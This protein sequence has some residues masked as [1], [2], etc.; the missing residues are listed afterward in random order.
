MENDLESSPF[1]LHRPSYPSL[2]H[3]AVSSLVDVGGCDINL[4]HGCPDHGHSTGTASTRIDPGLFPDQEAI[5][6]D[7]N[8]GS[9][10]NLVRVLYCGTEVSKDRGRVGFRS[11]L[12]LVVPLQMSTVR[13]VPST[14]LSIVCVMRTVPT[15]C[16]TH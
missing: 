6:P 13:C 9:R 5:E 3:V 8:I 16:H 12:D 14:G 7:G 15:R 2:V 1:L 11:D 4:G 10:Q